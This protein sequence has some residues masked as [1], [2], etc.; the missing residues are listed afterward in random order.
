MGDMFWRYFMWNFVGRQD[1]EQL[2]ADTFN[3]VYMHGGWL[4]GIDFIDEL[5]VGARTALPSEMENN[6]AHNTY[7]FLPLL[8][9]LLGLIYQ[10]NNDWRNF[11][12]VLLLFGMMGIALVVYF[13]TAPDEPR[14]RDY[15]YAGAFYAFSIWLG[16]GVMAIGDILLSLARKINPQRGGV[17][18]AVAT[19]LLTLSVPVVLATE[20]WDDM[21]V[22]DVTWRGILVVTI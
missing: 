18:A 20:N 2:E 12:V 13:N 10:L 16:I 14:E 7:F 1:D 5:Y 15:V 22:Q 21:I 11:F 3:R 19:V 4:S 9:G 8:L 6:P 17:V